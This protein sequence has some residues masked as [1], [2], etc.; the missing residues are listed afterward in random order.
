MR[1]INSLFGLIFCV[2]GVVLLCYAGFEREYI[3]STRILWLIFAGSVLTIVGS[4]GIL[5]GFRG[6]SDLRAGI[7]V[8]G[9]TVKTWVVYGFV[10]AEFCILMFQVHELLRYSAEIEPYMP[11]M[12]REGDAG[13]A[14]FFHLGTIV[15][16]AVCQIILLPYFQIRI[17]PTM[18][19]Q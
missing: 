2:F 16:P 10:F 17:L 13:V 19:Q 11:S 7:V 6:D 8:K 12:A 5:V 4:V 1:V 9:R 15:I 14:A 18:E 3:S